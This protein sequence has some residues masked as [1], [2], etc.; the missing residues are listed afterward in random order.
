MNTAKLTT[1]CRLI[2]KDFKTVVSLFFFLLFYRVAYGSFALGSVFFTSLVLSLQAAPHPGP[3]HAKTAELHL[4]PWKLG[5]RID[6]S[7]LNMH[8]V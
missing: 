6:T 2:I 3:L 7:V 4:H 1:L 8:H 5:R